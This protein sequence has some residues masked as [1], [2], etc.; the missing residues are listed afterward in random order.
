[1]RRRGRRGFRSLQ[2]ALGDD[3]DLDPGERVVAQLW[4]QDERA[5]T[6]G[7]L[8][9]APVLQRRAGDLL[10]SPSPEIVRGSSFGSPWKMS[11]VTAN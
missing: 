8:P 1:M 11:S 3:R 5:R 4:A 6:A 10:I 9:D 2:L 7:F